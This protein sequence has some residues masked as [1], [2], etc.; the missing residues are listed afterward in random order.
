MEIYDI[1]LLLRAAAVVLG[2]AAGA[3]VVLEQHA[4]VDT[5]L[6]DIAQ[7]LFVRCEVHVA[8]ARFGVDAAY[9][10]D[11]QTEDLRTVD[12]ARVDEVLDVRAYLLEALRAVLQLERIVGNLLD[13]VVLQVGD[14]E[15]HVVARNVHAGEVYGRVGQTEDIGTASARGLDLA[16]IIHYILLDKLLNEFRNGRNAYMQLFRKFRKR[17]LAVD[18]HV[19]DYVSL[20]YIVLVSDTL[21]VLI[22]GN[23]KEFC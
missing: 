17:T 23:V 18:G 16:Q 11:S 6:Y 21:Q 4:H 1:A 22:R 20:Y 14:N 19:G 5:L 2:I 9:D 7:R 3:G 10:R 13:K 12:A 15:G 8:A